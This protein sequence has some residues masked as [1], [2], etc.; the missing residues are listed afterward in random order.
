MTASLP[1]TAA[2]PAPS[3]GA[4]APGPLTVDGGRRRAMGGDAHLI[5]VVDG[6]GRAADAAR[7]L[8]AGWARIAELEDRWSRFLPGSEVSALNRAAGAPVAVSADTVLLVERAR[9]AWQATGGRFDPSVGAALVAHGYDRDL[10]AL[11]PPEPPDPAA[12]RPPSRAL[13]PLPAPGLGGVTV[14]HGGRSVTLPPGVTFDPGGIGKGLAAD[15]VADHLLAAGAAGALVNL[16]GD[17]R[18]AGRPP[19][20]EG[21]VIGVPHPLRPGTELARLA[22][23]GGA[24]A[25]SGTLRRRWHGPTG[26]VHH[27]FDP[28]TGR[29]ATT[30]VVGTTVVAAEG[31]WAE[32]QA[33]ALFLAGPA[34]LADLVGAHGLVVTVDGRIWSTSGLEGTWT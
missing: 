11:P 31:W 32:A 7:L 5:V 16:A 18:A 33:K 1:P 12:A 28:A 8:R 9:A 23:P 13:P 2:L 4:E 19:G 27:L 21:W 25:T 17:L 22:L 14:D 29:P 20:P 3:A 6:E 10:A 30:D 34:G 15:L 24:V 26:T